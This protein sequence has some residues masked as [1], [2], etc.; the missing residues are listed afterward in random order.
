[1]ENHEIILAHLESKGWS[2]VPLPPGLAQHGISLTVRDPQD[3]SY[4]GLEEAL[5]LQNERDSL[6]PRRARGRKK[7]GK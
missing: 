7:K 1:M 3:G 4:H 5:R 6:R 2:I